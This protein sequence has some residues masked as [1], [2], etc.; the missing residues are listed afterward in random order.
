MSPFFQRDR[1]HRRGQSGA[2]EHD[3]PRANNKGSGRRTN[4]E[5]TKFVPVSLGQSLSKLRLDFGETTS[6]VTRRFLAGPSGEVEAAIAYMD[7]LADKN[8]INDHILKST[9]VE[10]GQTRASN[11]PARLRPGD[12]VEGVLERL[13]SASEAEVT[14]EWEKVLSA[15][16]TGDTVILFNGSPRAIVVA[17]PGWP[18]RPVIEP[19]SETVVRGPRDGFTETIRVSETLIRRRIKDSRLRFDQLEI[20][21]LSKTKVSIGYIE[22]IVDQGIVDEVHE[23]L[24]RIDVDAVLESGYLEEYIQDSPWSLFPQMLR[25]ERP[26]TVAANLLEGRVVIFTDNTP[27]AL[28]VPATFS[29]FLSSPEDYYERFPIGSLIRILRYIAF[30]IALVLPALYIAITTFHQELLPTD[31]ILAIASAR[32]GVP[33]PAL[34]EALLLETLFEVLR[35][36]GIRLPRVIGQAVSIVGALV[37]GEAAVSAG[38][39]SP[40]MVIVVAMTAIA[41]F[42]TPVFSVAI[43]ARILRFVFM[44]AASMVGL[45]GIQIVALLLLLHLVSLRSFGVPYLS[46]IAPYQR[47]DLKDVVMRAP[48]WLMWTRPE[49]I[50]VQDRVREEP[51]LR[52]RPP[53]D[54]LRSSKDDL[55]SDGAD[56]DADDSQRGSGGRR[57]RTRGKRGDR[58]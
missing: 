31:L 10:A 47:S 25:T 51:N 58:S 35:E 33:F 12:V 6:L 7:G 52:M 53:A 39:V 41:S 14:R 56:K 5:G 38:L 34:V 46:P 50:N 17:T 18:Q 13:L 20:G 16:S 8:V 3:Q 28:I 22:G 1:R 29:M 37:V 11:A 19:P 55:E 30:V 32:Q 48:L 24:C 15:I 27:F 42:A 43:S 21:R 4:D 36:A 26:D 44:I 23:R 57:S 9:M 54:L 40:A 49:A 2:Q 45:F